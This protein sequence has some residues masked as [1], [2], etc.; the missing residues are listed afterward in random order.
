MTFLELWLVVYHTDSDKLETTSMKLKDSF[1]LVLASLHGG[2]APHER[3]IGTPIDGHDSVFIS[4]RD[5]HHL[6]VFASVKPR[7]RF[8]TTEPDRI[9]SVLEGIADWEATNDYD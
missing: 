9:T 7:H 4:R 3:S 2:G 1:G 6:T 5:M 8:F